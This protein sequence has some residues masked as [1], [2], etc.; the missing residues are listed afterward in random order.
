ML[1]I[2]YEMFNL[3]E[4][5]LAEAWECEQILKDDIVMQQKYW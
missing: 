5:S 4:K 1:E 3:T 2:V